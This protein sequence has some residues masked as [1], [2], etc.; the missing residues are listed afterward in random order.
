MN[1]PRELPMPAPQVTG[2]AGTGS[3]DDGAAGS[4][5]NQPKDKV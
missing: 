1:G 3:P 2:Q 4:E 5:K